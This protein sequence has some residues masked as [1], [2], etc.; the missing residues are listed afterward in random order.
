M[1][2]YNKTCLKYKELVLYAKTSKSYSII[3]ILA[4]FYI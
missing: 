3:K 1:D 4:I 2:E